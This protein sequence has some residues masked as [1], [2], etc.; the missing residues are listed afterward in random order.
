MI[1]TVTHVSE[2]NGTTTVTLR[3]GSEMVVMGVGV[4]VGSKC[5]IKDGQVT[6]PAPG[7]LQYDVEV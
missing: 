1:G 5:F 4:D 2:A 3:N 6:G 7:L